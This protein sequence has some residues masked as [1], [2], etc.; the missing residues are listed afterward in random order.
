M[1]RTLGGDPSLSFRSVLYRGISIIMGTSFVCHSEEAYYADVR[2]QVCHSTAAS[3]EGPAFSL[4]FRGCTSILGI[5]RLAQ[6]VILA[7]RGTRVFCVVILAENLVV[8]LVWMDSFVCYVILI[9]RPNLGTYSGASDKQ[10][11]ALLNSFLGCK[12]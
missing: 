7:C 5:Q 2:I 12:D 4:S 1:S 8:L 9:S 11:R 3:A 10:Q 6:M